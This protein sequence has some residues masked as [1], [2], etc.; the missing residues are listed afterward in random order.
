[1]L[2]DNLQIEGAIATNLMS[3]MDSRRRRQLQNN[4]NEEEL[5]SC[6]VA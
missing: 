4:V 5:R 3:S 1:M 6:H 2:A